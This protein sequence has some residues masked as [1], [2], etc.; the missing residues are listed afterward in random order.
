MT[1]FQST[2]TPNDASIRH[3]TLTPLSYM[4]DTLKCRPQVQSDP[5]PSTPGPR[6]YPILTPQSQALSPKLHVP[7]K[8][9]R[10]LNL[11]DSLEVASTI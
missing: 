3:L 5:Q 6:P 7:F 2:Q 1:L 9:D 4:R 10:F 11:N 8:A